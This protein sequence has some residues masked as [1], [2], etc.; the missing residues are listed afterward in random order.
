M[1]PGI[2]YGGTTGI[3]ADLLKDA[4]RAGRVIGDGSSRWPCVYVRDLA[5]LYVRVSTN[6]DAAGIPAS[7][8][9]D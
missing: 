9:A 8:G 3:V 5:D 1:R 2:V 6:P 4:K 7:D